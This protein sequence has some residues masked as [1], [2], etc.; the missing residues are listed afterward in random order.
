[1]FRLAVP[2][3]P[4]QTVACRRSRECQSPSRYAPAVSVQSRRGVFGAVCVIVCRPSVVVCCR[5]SVVVVAAAA[6]SATA[7]AVDV[8]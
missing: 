5:W 1:M 3:P 4:K 8:S 2:P 7:A 6:A